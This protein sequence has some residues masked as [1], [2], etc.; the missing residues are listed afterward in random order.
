MT[1]HLLL[2]E[3]IDLQKANHKSHAPMLLYASIS[4]GHGDFGN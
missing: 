4:T 3:L 2:C 1:E